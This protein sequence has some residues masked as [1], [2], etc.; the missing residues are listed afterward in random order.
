MLVALPI[1]RQYARKVASPEF[2]EPPKVNREIP[3]LSVVAGR[4]FNHPVPVDTFIDVGPGDVMTLSALCADGRPLPGWL[5]FDQAVQTFHGS[6]PEGSMSE[7]S[8]EVVATDF[9]GAW[10]SQRFTIRVT[11]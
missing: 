5:F 10:V 6:S 3:D 11:V 4:P 1:G 7:I 9:D 2:N 8:I